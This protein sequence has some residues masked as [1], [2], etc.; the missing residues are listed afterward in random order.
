MST[1]WLICPPNKNFPSGREQKVPSEAMLS[2][3]EFHRAA[4]WR[5]GRD[6][7]DPDQKPPNSNTKNHPLVVH[8][9]DQSSGRR[10]PKSAGNPVLEKALPLHRDPRAADRRTGRFSKG[11]ATCVRK[12]QTS[13]TLRYTIHAYYI[14]YYIDL[15]CMIYIYFSI[16]IRVHLHYIHT[17]Y[18]SFPFL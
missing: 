2:F 15:H 14:T 12:R 5:I 16:C 10:R 7:H 6:A 13:V 4:C 18:T 3:Q 9:I 11:A 8:W 17:L 1:P